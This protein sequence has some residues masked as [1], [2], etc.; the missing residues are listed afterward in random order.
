MK[1]NRLGVQHHLFLL[2]FKTCAAC[3]V[4]HI[5][6]VFHS[7]TMCKREVA[8]IRIPQII[9]LWNLDFNYFICLGYPVCMPSSCHVGIPCDKDVGM[10]M[11]TLDSHLLCLERCNRWFLFLFS[12]FLLFYIYFLHW[13]PSFIESWIVSLGINLQCVHAC[14][15]VCVCKCLLTLASL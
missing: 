9:G 2:V 13:K 10:K 12:P 6:S 11:H 3:D 15:R 7:T 8:S 4:A 14:T 1:L 5:N